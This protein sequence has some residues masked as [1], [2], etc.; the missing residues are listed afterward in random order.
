MSSTPNDGTET[1]TVPAYLSTT[2]RIK[3]Q[4]VGNIFFDISNTNF[5]IAAGSTVLS[6]LNTSAL[7]TTTYCSGSTVSI[8]FS[9]DGPAN[10]G[11]VFTAQLS[12]SSGSFANPINIG[13]LTST[14]NTGSISCTIPSNTA[15]GNAYRIRVIASN[16]VITGTDNGANITIQNPITTAG[17]VT[18]SNTI[19]QGQTNITYSTVAVTNA[20]TYTWTNL[21]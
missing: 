6:T 4:S 13:T 14:S 7:T 3:V 2:A 16:P 8:G 15:A 11:N 1:I 12:N 9:G 18:G 10:T 19:C 20:S 17:V 5:T 21:S